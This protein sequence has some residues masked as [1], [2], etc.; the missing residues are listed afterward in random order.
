M[1]IKDEP[2]DRLVMLID[3]MRVLSAKTVILDTG[4]KDYDK[5]ADLL[6]KAGA[7]VD[8]IPWKDDFSWARNQTLPHLDTDWTLHL[9]ADELPSVMM[10]TFIERVL[11]ETDKS[12]HGVLFFTRNFWGGEWGIE[13]PSHWHVRM[14]RTK[15]AE[16]YKPI[17]ECVMLNGLQESATRGSPSMIVAPKEAYLIHSKPR[18]KIDASTELYE[19]MKGRGVT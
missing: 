2:V 7:Y 17:H 14:F 13:V 18:E 19:G 3:Y 16:W 8:Q 11:S 15:M 4:S 12:Q 6:R 1:I 5:D 9:D 10:M